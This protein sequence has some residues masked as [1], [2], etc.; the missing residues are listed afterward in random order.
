MKSL[1]KISLVALSFIVLVTY[2]GCKGKKQTDPSVEEVQL[3]ALSKSWKVSSVT[4]NNT[5]DI[6]YTSSFILT[7]SGTAGSSSFGYTVSGRPA[8]SPWLGT[9]SWSFGSTVES[10]IVRD[11]G[12]ADELPITYSVSDTNLKLSFDFSGPGYSNSK[13]ENVAGPWVFNMVPN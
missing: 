4:H 3:K 6:A 5:I 1:F 9:G 10:Q 8:T 12:T 11:K 2:S 13:V 7:I